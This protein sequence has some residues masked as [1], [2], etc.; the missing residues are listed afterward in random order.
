MMTNLPC[1]SDLKHLFTVE[2]ITVHSHNYLQYTWLL[3]VM[4]YIY[5]MS[6][7]VLICVYRIVLLLGL[8]LYKR[9]YQYSYIFWICQIVTR[10]YWLWEINYEIVTSLYIDFDILTMML[11]MILT[12][13]YDMIV[14]MM[15]TVDYDVDRWLW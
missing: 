14:T 3:T 8:H 6:Q 10:R 12:V 15:L 11:T 2:L 9:L 13:D 5:R 7:W 4:M 1:F